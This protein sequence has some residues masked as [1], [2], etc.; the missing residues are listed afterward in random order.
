MPVN[1]TPAVGDPS[2]PGCRAPSGETRGYSG[3]DFG[4]T[5]SPFILF[6]SFILLDDSLPVGRLASAVDGNAASLSLPDQQFVQPIETAD[7]VV[8][9]IGLLPR[10]FR[11]EGA[12]GVGVIAPDPPLDPPER[13][14]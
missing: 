6:S 11:I 5:L 12:G 3:L 8:D 4:K 9:V 10:Y 7:D 14:T 2:S 13:G 1:A